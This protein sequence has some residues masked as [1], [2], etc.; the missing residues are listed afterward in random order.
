VPNRLWWRVVP[1][2]VLV[3]LLAGCSLDG[4]QSTFA[5][6]GPIAQEQLDLFMWTYY[7]SWPVVIIVVGV[8]VYVI[9]RFRRRDDA[10]PAQT[11]GNAVLEVAWTILP[12]IIVVLVAV[13]AI[14]SVFRTQAFV[15][16]GPSD[17]VIHVTGYQ[18][19]WK[20]D[21]VQHGFVTANEMHIPVG[22]RVVLQV[23]SADVLHAFWVPRMGGKIDLIPNQDNQLWFE[24]SE[25]GVFHGQCAE[26]CLGAHAYMRLRVVVQTQE[27]YEDWVAS[28]QQPTVQA[29]AADPLVTQGRQLVASK[30][31]I[32]CHNVGNYAEGMR[33]G[34]PSFPDLTNFGLRV[35]VGAGML[36]ATLD[37]VAA[38]IADPQS[39]KPGNR[40]PTLWAENDPN[41]EQEARA[42]ATYLL[43]LGVPPADQA[44]IDAAAG[45]N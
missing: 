29:V 3:L 25:T 36:D 17:V 44:S 45:G 12:V 34:Q 20:F 31:C 28:F 41:R 38:W 2:C 24:A 9:V 21:Y 5:P 4:P 43:S 26:L 33:L 32:G 22:A 39:V 10:I 19:W 16:A 13:P 27:E 1:A 8:L 11:H 35:S 15:D 14:R 42:I 6:A 30:G 37:N 7:L 18:W 23:S 40:M